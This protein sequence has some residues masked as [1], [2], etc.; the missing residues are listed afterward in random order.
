MNT[1]SLLQ[2]I[3]GSVGVASLLLCLKLAIGGS[4]FIAWLR[5]SVAI[6]CLVLSAMATSLIF[7]LQAYESLNS[8]APVAHISFTEF[9][10]EVYI[11]S[12]E[13]KGELRSFE[14]HGDQWQLDTR[15]VNWRDGKGEAMFRLSN[16]SGRHLTKPIQP[17]SER[18]AYQLGSS[19][20]GIDTWS[21]LHRFRDKLPW[22]DTRYG[23][24][25][26]MPMAHNAQY[27]LV[28][29]DSVLQAEPVNPVALTAAAD[30]L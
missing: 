29:K 3:A 27:Q 20:Y 16:F 2:L 18:F 14:L 24:A 10:P 1:L 13:M 23:R 7:D 30:W 11:A 8:D 26:Y 17:G 15:I 19:A 6:S 21:L 12:V 28:L 25:I 9:K 22:L 4:W 5:G